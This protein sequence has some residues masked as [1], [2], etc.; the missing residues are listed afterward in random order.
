LDTQIEV[1]PWERAARDQ[2]ILEQAGR[3]LKASTIARLH[4]L[5][6]ERVRQI[7][8]AAGVRKATA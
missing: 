4:K 3:G 7:I 1:Q 5:S 8:K 6:A 2:Q